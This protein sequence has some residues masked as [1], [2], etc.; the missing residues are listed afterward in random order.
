MKVSLISISSAIILC[1]S[2]CSSASIQPATSAELKVTHIVESTDESYS[3]TD[4]VYGV[5]CKYVKSDKV[6]TELKCE[7]M[8]VQDDW[9]TPADGWKMKEKD[10]LTYINQVYDENGI[11]LLPIDYGSNTYR[12]IGLDAK[13]PSC[14]DCP[15]ESEE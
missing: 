9:R 13:D 7:Q 1:L 4:T 15:S 5:E 14:E 12:I 2:A 3:T 10:G 6:Y 11:L 8:V